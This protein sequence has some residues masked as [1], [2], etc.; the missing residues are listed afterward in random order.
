MG[1]FRITKVE[2]LNI[3]KAQQYVESYEQSII[4]TRR[5]IMVVAT[6]DDDNDYHELGCVPK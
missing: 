5:H 3:M 2:P 6:A 4:A 1:M